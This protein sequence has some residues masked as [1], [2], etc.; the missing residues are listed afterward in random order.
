MR[1]SIVIL[2]KMDRERIL[3]EVTLIRL[4]GESHKA[5]RASWVGNWSARESIH[6]YSVKEGELAFLAQSSERRGL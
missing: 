3:D 2:Y 4:E 5:D 6:Y 1:K